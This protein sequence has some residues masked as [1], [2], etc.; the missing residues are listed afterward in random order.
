APRRPR[1]A[2]GRERIVMEPG[3]PSFRNLLP[4]DIRFGEGVVAELGPVV[5]GEGARRAFAVIDGV[6]GELPEVVAALAALA[7]AD[8]EVTRYQKEPGEPTA[9]E[10]DALSAAIGEADA[11]ILIAIGGGSVIDVAK[12]ARL[13]RSARVPYLTVQDDLT[14]AAAAPDLP[15]VAV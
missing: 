3:V 12:A 6:A 14:L 7:E 4:V 11:D 1:P 13:A 9:R 8:V 5:R 15:L 2:C 10:S